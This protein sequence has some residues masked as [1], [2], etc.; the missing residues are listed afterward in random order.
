[1]SMKEK[2]VAF[3]IDDDSFV[4]EADTFE[5]LMDKLRKMGLLERVYVVKAHS[6][7]L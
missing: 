4:A 5:D 2:Y 6:F 1:M 7:E 3:R